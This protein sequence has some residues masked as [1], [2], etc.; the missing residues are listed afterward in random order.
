MSITKKCNKVKYKDKLS[1]MIA[2]ASCLSLHNKKRMET[3]YYW[4]KEC[5]AYHLTKMNKKVYELY[6]W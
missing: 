5:N 6:K 3:R 1:A 2:L 4:C